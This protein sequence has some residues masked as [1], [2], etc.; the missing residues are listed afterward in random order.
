MPPS[1]PSQ[2]FYLLLWH[3]TPLQPGYNTTK[4]TSNES[5]FKDC[6]LDSLWTLRL[7]YRTFQPIKCIV[8]GSSLSLIHI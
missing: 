6:Y 2:A 8:T 3:L 1:Y 4:I 5:H 7:R